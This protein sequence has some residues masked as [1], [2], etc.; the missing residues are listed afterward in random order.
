MSRLSG[1]AATVGKAQVSLNPPCKVAGPTPQF[2]YHALAT[3]LGRVS[4]RWKTDTTGIQPRNGGSESL[5]EK[6]LPLGN[7]DYAGKV[8][9]SRLIGRNESS[10]G[11]DKTP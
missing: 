5:V 6:A 2:C 4:S 8:D 1:F 11:A 3:Y 9:G 10:Q 7:R